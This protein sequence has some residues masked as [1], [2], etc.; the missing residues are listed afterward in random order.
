VFLGIVIL[1][2]CSV[3]ELNGESVGLDDF[4]LGS[5]GRSFLLL[6]LQLLDSRAIVMTLGD[7]N[8]VVAFIIT[9][10]DGNSDEVV[11]IFEG[12]ERTNETADL[13]ADC[14]IRKAPLNVAGISHDH[15]NAQ[16]SVFTSEHVNDSCIVTI[17]EENGVGI[18]LD[19]VVKSVK[20]GSWRA[21]REG[22]P[23]DKL[24]APRD[25]A[26]E[27]NISLVHLIYQ[28]LDK[29]GVDIFE[30][31][32]LRTAADSFVAIL[33]C[34]VEIDCIEE[35]SIDRGSKVLDDI[36]FLS[37]GGDQSNCSLLIEMTVGQEE[38]LQ[39]G[40][41]KDQ[42]RNSERILLKV[43]K[44]RPRWHGREKSITEINRRPVAHDENL[45][46]VLVDLG[47]LGDGNTSCRLQAEALDHFLELLNAG[48]ELDENGQPLNFL[49]IDQNW[50]I[51]DTL[52]DVIWAHRGD[53]GEKRTA[54]LRFWAVAN[55]DDVELALLIET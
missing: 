11:R 13:V 5:L 28:F 52:N 4:D 14:A 1:A 23:D 21:V 16:I 6:R 37:A 40:A 12:Q 29:A 9:L 19:D 27:W 44:H 43:A 48:I 20:Q 33:I 55:R 8:Q 47:D 18:S 30:H 42:R 7:F 34:E 10:N 25:D 51:A 31:D 49:R 2:S 17:F 36:K 41:A 50:Y 15:T 24:I 35:L 22:H 54:G 45:E 39:A 3:L 26:C 46:Q 38:A 53:D 32:D